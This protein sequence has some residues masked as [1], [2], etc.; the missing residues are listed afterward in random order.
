ML[1]NNCSD[2]LFFSFNKIQQL[3]SELTI[4]HLKT[5]STCKRIINELTLPSKTNL[6]CIKEIR[7]SLNELEK[8]RALSGS[9]ESL[10]SKRSQKYK[11]LGLKEKKLSEHELKDLIL[12]EYTFLKRPVFMFEDGIYI[13]NSKKTIALLKENKNL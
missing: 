5:C 9:Y 7:I 13:G 12:K 4:Y 11:A 8:M 3:M 6:K 10:F 2:S 1:S